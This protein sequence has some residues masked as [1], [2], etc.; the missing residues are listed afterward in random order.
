MICRIGEFASMTELTKETLSYYAE[1]K[2]LE[3]VYVNP[4]SHYAN[5]DNNSYLTVRLLY[6]LRNF[7]FS[8]Q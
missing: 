7:D 2:L 1:I 4:T 6:Y 3:P 5:Y 8:I